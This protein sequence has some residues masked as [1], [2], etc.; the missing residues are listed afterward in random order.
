MQMETLLGVGTVQ[1]ITLFMSRL[2][3]EKGTIQHGDLNCL[4]L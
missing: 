4:C 1:K 2:T 3:S